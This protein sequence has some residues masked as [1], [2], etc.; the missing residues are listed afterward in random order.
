MTPS[1]PGKQQSTPGQHKPNPIA[2]YFGFGAGKPKPAPVRELKKTTGRKKTKVAAR[3][4]KS[5]NKPTPAEQQ[6]NQPV[7]A[8]SFSGH[9]IT[10]AIV[11]VIVALTV[12]TPLTSFIRQHNEIKTTEESIAALQAEQDSLNAQISW[13]QDDN[14]VKQQAR[15]RLFYVQPGETPYL[16]VGLDSASGLADDTSAAAKTAPEDAWTTKLWGSLQLAADDTASP[17][18]NSE[19]SPAASSEPS[20]PA[21]TAPSETVSPAGSGSGTSTPSAR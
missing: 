8:H 18:A 7:A 6:L 11:L 4:A 9:F 19:P 2:A 10:F 13:W 1:T 3:S 17:A 14:Y 5:P 21:A 16:V 15:S 20:E 12:Y